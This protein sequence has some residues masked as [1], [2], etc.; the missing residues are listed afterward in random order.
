MTDIGAPVQVRRALT[1]TT[2][3]LYHSSCR[4]S[5][6]RCQPPA[7][8]DEFLWTPA[9]LWSR[10]FSRQLWWHLVTF[11]SQT[12]NCPWGD[13]GCRSWR[14]E[15]PKEVFGR[16][17]AEMPQRYS[18]SHPTAKRKTGISECAFW[19]RQPG[20]ADSWASDHLIFAWWCRQGRVHS[21]TNM[22]GRG[23]IRKWTFL[24]AGVRRGEVDWR[25]ARMPSLHGQCMIF[26]IDCFL[27]FL[28]VLVV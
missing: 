14:C 23:T 27:W 28:I 10:P 20:R 22:T 13:W 9:Q 3:V 11:Y 7:R 21:S 16:F 1:C 12:L 19:L 4:R 8:L 26:L 2:P 5:V 17:S 18:V 25:G 15:L 24:W 6:S